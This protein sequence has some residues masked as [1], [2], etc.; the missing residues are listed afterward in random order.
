MSKRPWPGS[1]EAYYA[2]GI[3]NEAQAAAAVLGQNY[4]DSEWYKDSYKLLQSGGLEPRES[5]GSWLS[6]A[7]Y[8]YHWWQRRRLV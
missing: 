8:G 1:V 3:T 4:P 7:A 5:T 6:K 2:M